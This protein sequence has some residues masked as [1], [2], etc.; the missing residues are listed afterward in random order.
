[1]TNLKDVRGREI[2]EGV[3]VYYPVRRGSAMWLKSIYVTR[4]VETRTGP[5]LIGQ[6][7]ENRRIVLRRP[8]RCIVVEE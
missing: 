6:N 1:M 3:T 8:E 5:Q 7:K 4:V 2:K